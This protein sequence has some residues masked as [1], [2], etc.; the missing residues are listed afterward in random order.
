MRADADVVV[1]GGGLAAQRCC[2]GL[3]RGG[4]D[5]RIAVLCEEKRRPY[6]RPP[7]SKEVLSGQ[8]AGET[9][10]LRP[11]HW[12]R[13]Q[14][15]ELVGQSACDLDP[16]ACTVGLRGGGRLRY[17]SLV[18]ATGSRP[19]RLPLLAAATRGVH[20]L[21]TLADALALR[22][23]LT[24]GI[25]RLAIVGA[26]MIGMEVASS[27]RALGLQVTLL[28]AAPV[29]LARALPPSLGMW[30]AGLHRRRGIDVRL[31]TTVERARRRPRAIS[32]ALS[33]GS[34]LQ[35]GAVLVAA[36]IAPATAWLAHSGLG[37]GWIET[38]QAGRTRIPGIYAAGDAASVPDPRSGRLVPSQHWEGAARGGAA[39]ARTLLGMPA[40]APAPAMF[41]TDQ[42]GLRIQLVGHAPPGC[43]IEL[44]GDPGADDFT[45]WLYQSATPAAAMLVG[46][47][48]ELPRVRRLIAA[49]EAPAATA[50]NAKEPPCPIYR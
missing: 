49:R 2:E 42:H 4:F 50:I 23:A 47:P 22:E 9:L 11:A 15:I 18:I 3:R 31:S 41:W 27:A 37:S 20:E 14:R 46:R 17:R 21:R 19:R 39:V 40:P 30:L 32:L 16:A 10:A 7:L 1:A 36:G 24:S 45:A 43:R 34:E 8:R 13:E 33:D 26:G 44:D 12:Y 35:A 5:G 29:P 38:D 6:D 48:G 28:E 25:E